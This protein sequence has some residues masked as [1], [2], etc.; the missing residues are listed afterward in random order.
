[1]LDE[2]DRGETAFPSTG[3]LLLLLFETEATSAL[4]EVEC[5]ELAGVGDEGVAGDR[6]EFALVEAAAF[7]AT[8]SFPFPNR[9]DARSA[10]ARS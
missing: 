10:S 3:A 5:A 1:M 9:T 7:A 6:A 8:L 4:G 2:A